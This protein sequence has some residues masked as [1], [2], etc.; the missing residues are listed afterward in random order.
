[1]K[2][3]KLFENYDSSNK[4]VFYIGE[5]KIILE[6][7]DKKTVDLDIAYYDIDT[8][9]YSFNKIGKPEPNFYKKIKNI[10]KSVN[11]TEI[12]LYVLC[13]IRLRLFKMKL[14]DNN[15][16][17]KENISPITNRKYLIILKDN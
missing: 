13:D 4:N 16:T 6:E 3:I 5:Y 7:R 2:Y 14:S 1:M 12:R 15:W 11:Y 17:I 10:I 8:D 9:T